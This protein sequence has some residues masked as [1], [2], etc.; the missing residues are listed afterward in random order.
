M[1]VAY[2]TI[3]FNN[4]YFNNGADL[5]IITGLAL[6]NGS[7]PTK[8]IA[9]GRNYNSMDAINEGDNY[10]YLFIVD[11]S[12]GL[13]LSKMSSVNISGTT[14]ANKRYDLMS[15]G[16][17]WTMENYVYIAWNMVGPEFED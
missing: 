17:N 2:N 13:V 12:S 4:F 11:T 8:L 7:S 16:I 6:E 1:N 15:N 3:V 5:N 9:H 14:N 10:G